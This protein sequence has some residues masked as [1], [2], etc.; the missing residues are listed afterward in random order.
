MT[1]SDRKIFSFVKRS[2]ILFQL[3]SFLEKCLQKM[4]HKSI[5][6]Q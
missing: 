4:F 1:Q 2:E 6:K 5:D 3:K